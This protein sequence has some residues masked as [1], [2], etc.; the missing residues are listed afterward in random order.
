MIENYF[1]IVL[2]WG[3]FFLI[4]KLLKDYTLTVLFSFLIMFIGVFGLSGGL[5][6]NYL[7]QGISIIHLFAG[8]YLI[9]KS[10]IKLV[11]ETEEDNFGRKLGEW[12]KNLKKSK[13]QK[14]QKK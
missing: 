4:F 11:E 3:L 10:S 5:G 7:I 6:N 12:L 8:L 13:N 9:V 2:I 14:N 1:F